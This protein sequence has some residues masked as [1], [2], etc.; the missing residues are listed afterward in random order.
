MSVYSQQGVKTRYIQPSSFNQNQVEFKLD[1]HTSYFSNL[2]LCG[3]G[4]LRVD[5]GTYADAS[6]AYGLI[7]SIYLTSNGKVIDGLRH[8]NRY[9]AFSNLLVDNVHSACVLDR[10]AKTAIGMQ[11][12]ST[13]KRL[14]KYGNGSN[15]TGP[16]ATLS[17]ARGVFGA[18]L[19]LHKVFPVLSELSSID[20]DMM[21]N[22]SIRI[23]FEPNA[24]FTFNSTVTTQ[25]ANGSRLEPV[26]V[27]DEIRDPAQK[28][29]LRNA[30]QPVVWSS[31]ENDRVQIDAVTTA[32]ADGAELKQDVNVKMLGFNDKYV[33]RV[34]FAKAH[35]DLSVVRSGT[36]NIG[37]GPYSSP[38]GFKEVFQLR[39]NGANLLAGKGLD[40][41]NSALMLLSDT[42]GAF[43]CAPF[44]N[45]MSVGAETQQN[46]STRQAGVRGQDAGTNR[47]GDKIGQMG[48]IGLS[49]EDKVSDLQVSYQRTCL[50]DTNGRNRTK[51]AIDLH[52]FAEV[53]KS[54]TVE[55]GRMMVAYV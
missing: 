51:Y 18:Y 9:L 28:E 32:I 2:R 43:S 34:V 30:F 16:V 7:R 3:L 15:V 19:P 44:D 29:A 50:A 46:A 53:R 37:Y 23:E 22:V 8:A 12:D 25:T 27:A 14:V 5:S 33:S 49:I 31:I 10:E 26:L 36:T 4:D 40:N 35:A 48:Y 42:Y 20:T 54:L 13:K 47:Q 6:G 55:G 11:V 21:P 39:L 24:Q 17:N 41:K 38:S 1:N 52:A 45:Q